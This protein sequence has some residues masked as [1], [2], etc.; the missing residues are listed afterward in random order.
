MPEKNKTDIR[1][2]TTRDKEWNKYADAAPAPD[3]Y[4]R[5]EYA[6]IYE[7]AY[8]PAVDATFGGEA[9]LFVHGTKDDFVAMPLMKRKIDGTAFFDLASPY[10]YTGP[11][12]KT[13]LGNEKK[14][15][16]EFYEAL[17]SYAKKKGIVSAFVRFNPLLQNQQWDAAE[18]M[19]N[20]V[21]VDLRKS[22]STLL[23]EMDKK[24]RTAMRKAY[25]EGVRVDVIPCGKG[26][27]EEREATR[28]LFF[29]YIASMRKR[30][31]AA[32][33]FFPESFFE[34]TAR[35]LGKQAAIFIARYKETPI[36]AA[37]FMHAYGNM[38]Y[39]F[40]GVDP[41]YQQLYPTNLLIA[42]TVRWGKK[43]GCTFLHLGG[44]TTTS[45][46]DP[47]FRF[48]AA[49]ARDRREYF[50]KKIVL[51]EKKYNELAARHNEELKQQGKEPRRGFFPAY[52]A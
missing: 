17:G 38:H 20:T 5:A 36:A 30:K 32:H 4:F 48:K 24:A 33:Y 51:D 9:L 43:Q 46:Q 50:L 22:E 2:Y 1:V 3:I 29:L 39:H 35:L 13:S 42:E 6:A 26:G 27:E 18:K 14:R 7:Q 23:A 25:K 8:T 16:M 34:T 45:D 28:N 31:A 15:V 19:N 11:L 12:V 10:G 47:L 21:V 49:F 44:G 52:R 37:L 40:S 41:E